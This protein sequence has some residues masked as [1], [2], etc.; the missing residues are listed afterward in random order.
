MGFHPW[1]TNYFTK[2]YRDASDLESATD[3][4]VRQGETTSSIDVQLSEGG[5]IT[6]TV[7]LEISSARFVA[8]GANPLAGV[9]IEAY[10]ENG[11]GEWEWA[12]SAATNGTGQYDISGLATGTY[13]VG[14][15]EHSGFYA[16]EYYENASDLKNATDITVIAGE[17]TPNI[18][19][20]LGDAAEPL[21]NASSLRGRVTVDTQTGEITIVQQNRNKSDVTISQV[22]T[23]SDG[24]APSDVTLMV[25]QNSYP[26]MATDNSKQYAVTVPAAQVVDG[27][28]I[29]VTKV[30]NDN[31]DEEMIGQIELFDPNG[32]VTDATTG[33]PIANA[34]LTLYNVPS[35]QARTGAGQSGTPNTCQSN[36]SKAA[37]DPWS[38]TAPIDLGVMAPTNSGAGQS[39]TNPFLTDAEGYYGWDVAAGCWYVVVEATGYQT[40][41]SP[42]VG[43]PPEVTDLNLALAQSNTQIVQFSAT[44]YQ[45]NEKQ[46][47][48]TIAITLLR[49]LT[50][51]VTLEYNT[52]NQTATAGK[53]YTP[54]NG[55]VSI[56]AGETVKTFSVAIGDDD[57]I[58]TNETIILTLSNPDKGTL[59]PRN[60]ATLMIVDDD[61]PQ[62]N[63]KIYLPLLTQPAR[64]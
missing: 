18:D 42:V 60:Q 8:G 43:V 4:S 45:V 58:E 23:C 48:A 32:Y 34:N 64:R 17:T 41:V 26:M 35:W 50:K 53:D 39:A 24:E 22:V 20:A 5:H 25:G 15:F 10:R 33:D 30:C 1:S 55:Q 36:L 57:T 27:A 11:L 13:R 51:T 14:F 47:S 44:T 61:D 54:S 21:A 7:T 62:S 37:N 59:G 49:P 63:P 29:K 9:Q 52:S 38:Q 28:E 46:E 56:P 31:S 16:Y 12:G 3:V 2:Y 6:G 19:A 40:L